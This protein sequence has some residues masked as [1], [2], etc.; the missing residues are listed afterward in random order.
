MLSPSHKTLLC[1]HG[2]TPELNADSDTHTSADGRAERGALSPFSPLTQLSHGFVALMVCNSAVTD[3]WAGKSESSL[4]RHCRFSEGVTTACRVRDLCTQWPQPPLHQRLSLKITSCKVSAFPIAHREGKQLS[5]TRSLSKSCLYP[6]HQPCLCMGELETFLH[7]S[8]DDG[9]PLA[10]R[11]G[12]ES[13]T[14]S[15]GLPPSSG[16]RKEQVGPMAPCISSHKT[17]EEQHPVPVW[18]STYTSTL[19]LASAGVTCSCSMYLFC[20]QWK[21][22]AVWELLSSILQG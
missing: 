12:R 17:E 15:S 6:W 11:M 19:H 18:L 21:I 5:A 10:S 4:T 13:D 16:E 7:I 8:Q 22:D 2:L 9:V 3:Q 20:C 14:W 1:V